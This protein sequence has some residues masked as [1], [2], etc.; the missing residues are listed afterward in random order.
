M[1]TPCRFF[2]V[3]SN[4]LHAGSCLR[5]WLLKAPGTVAG[6]FA[7]VSVTVRRYGARPPLLVSGSAP[8]IRLRSG[9]IGKGIDR[10][11]GHGPRVCCRPHRDPHWQIGDSE[12]AI[13]VSAF[14]AASA[15]ARRIAGGARPPPRAALPV[16]AAL[17]LPVM[18]ICGGLTLLAPA[19]RRFGGRGASCC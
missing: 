18:R 6:P 13:P 10:D 2:G 1:D 5:M 11:A 15:L 8:H 16:S 3:L 9:H 14:F 12:A 4:R 7:F 19:G 17:A